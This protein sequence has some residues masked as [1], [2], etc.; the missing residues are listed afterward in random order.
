MSAASDMPPQSAHCSRQQQRP[1]ET[2]ATAI[3]SEAEDDASCYISPPATA[4]TVPAVL[5]HPVQ[6]EAV[7][8]VQ[9][10]YVSE[11]SKNVA[12]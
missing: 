7:S 1:N 5:F 12:M 11:A 10:D 9:R 6:Q 4:A 8:V 2:S 3:I